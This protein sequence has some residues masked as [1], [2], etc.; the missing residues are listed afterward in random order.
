METDRRSLLKGLAAA[1]TM[2]VVSTR[3][4]AAQARTAPSDAVAMLYD[5]TRCI[6][7]KTCVVACKAAGGLAPDVDGYGGG[8]YDAPE[9]LNEYSR[10]VIQLAKSG[11]R[12]SFVKKQCMHCVDPACVN[13]CMLG[14]L[15]KGQYGIVS[16]DPAKCVGCRYCEVACPF[17]APRF[18]WSSTAPRIVKCDFCRDRVAEGKEPACV[19]TCPRD[20]IVFGRRDDLLAEA[21]RRI[22]SKPELY[23][24]KVYGEFELGG[25]QVLYLSHVPFEDLGFR[26]QQAESVPARQR[27]VQRWMYGGVIAPLALLLGAFTFRNRGLAGH[28]DNPGEGA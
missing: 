16:W 2:T 13:A 19:E 12:T 3:G 4:E 9:A 17:G 15:S 21:H 7:C 25:T 1:A 20:A 23:V 10:T 22:D 27:T 11:D 14:S 28:D 18:E 24:P 8:L 5:T 6:G 26:F